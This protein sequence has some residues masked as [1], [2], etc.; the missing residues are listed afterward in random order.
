[1]LLGV[2][3]FGGLAARYFAVSKGPSGPPDALAGPIGSGHSD[4][5]K[6]LGDLK[7]RPSIDTAPAESAL[8]PLRSK[9]SIPP[10][11]FASE[12][13]AFG[14]DRVARTVDT[15][16]EI[17]QFEKGAPE[18]KRWT[19]AAPGVRALFE[20]GASLGA[21]VAGQVWLF[22]SGRQE[23]RRTPGVTMFPES[24][25]FPDLVTRAHLLVLHPRTQS[26]YRYELADERGSLLPIDANHQLPE[27]DGRVFVALRDGSFVYSTEAGFTRLY[28]SG[29]TKK[30]VVL[31]PFTRSTSTTRP[32]C[33]STTS[34]P[35]TC[36]RE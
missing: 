14:G 9:L 29:R 2:V 16:V 11:T 8:V 13:L 1:L 27:F 28:A 30:L 20:M 31:R 18:P 3:L 21:L 34:Q 23:P 15:G 26:I 7:P 5:R 4:L 6:V 33:F 32:P 17:V 24:R 36:L 12:H 25:V 35:T 10:R 22:D 19:V